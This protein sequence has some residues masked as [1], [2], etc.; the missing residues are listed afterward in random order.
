MLEGRAGGLGRFFK[1]K[2]DFH[3]GLNIVAQRELFPQ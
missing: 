3:N 1:M 2:I